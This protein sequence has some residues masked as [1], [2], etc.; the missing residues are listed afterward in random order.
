MMAAT[1][2]ALAYSKPILMLPFDHR[3]SFSKE[4]LGFEGELTKSQKTRVSE[5]KQIVYEGFLRSA[6]EPKDWF[7]ILVDEEYGSAVL[8][9]ARRRGHTVAMPLEKSGQQEFSFDTPHWQQRIKE[10]NPDILKVLVRYNPANKELNKRQ[11]EKLAQASDYC[12]RAG[13]LFLFELLVPPTP[14][15]VKRKDYD[16]ITRPK[17]VVQAIKEIQ[18]SV[19]VDIWKIEGLTKAQWK[20]VIAATKL[21][22]KEQQPVFIVLG[23]NATTA[24][25]DTWLHAAAGY[26]EVTGFAVGRSIFYKPLERYRDHIITREHAITEIAVSFTHFSTV[27]LRAKR[28]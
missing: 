27:W 23:R 18:Q 13:K 12:L 28:S 19:S 10:M 2:A 25:V 17:L 14:T 4:L 8:K 11:L 20:P 1:K 7:A 5:M 22:K 3:S 24:T 6:A 21:N 16:K 15:Q 26:A 9:D